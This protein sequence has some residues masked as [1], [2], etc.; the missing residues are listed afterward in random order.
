MSIRKLLAGL[1]CLGLAG[2]ASPSPGPLLPAKPSVRVMQAPG[3]PPDKP[4]QAAAPEDK[5]LQIL[6]DEGLK[7]LTTALKTLPTRRRTVAKGEKLYPIE[8]NLQ[9]ADLVEAVRALADTLGLN[10]SIDPKVKGTVNVRASGRLTRGELLSILE[11]MLLVNG[12]ALVQIGKTYN[13]VPLEKAAGEGMPVYARDLPAAGMTAQVVLLDAAPAKEMAA[14][15]KPL[16]SAGGKIAEAPNNSLVI[17][18]YPANLE[19]LVHLVN[20]VDKQGLAKTSVSVV[21]VKNTDPTQI[22]P[23]LE[24]IFGAYGALSP[25]K[26]KGRGGVQFLAMPRMNAVMILAPSPQLMQRAEYWVRQLDLKTDTLA[27]IHVYNVENYRAR[28]LAD[29]LIQVYG[30]QVERPGVREIRPEPTPSWAV[31][32][33][34][35]LGAGEGE[36]EGVPRTGGGLTSGLGATGTTGLGATGRAPGL[37]TGLGPGL[38]PAAPSPRERALPLRGAA[39]AQELKEGVRIIPDEEN[40]L[41][42]IVA[43][44]YEWKIIQSLLKRLDVQPRQVMCEVLIAEITLTDDLR[45]GVEWFIN[46]RVASE[47]P[48]IIQPSPLAGNPPIEILKG[49]SAALQGIGGFTFAA[50]DALNQFRLVINML[51]TK[52]LVQVLASP[53]I[54]AANNQEAR[55]QI[56][57]EVPILTS[58]SIPLVSQTQSLQTQTVSYRSTGIILLVRPQI[59][60]KGM[61]TLDISQEVSAIDASAPATGVNSPTFLIRQARTSLITADNQTIILGGLIREDV[62]RGG[63]GVPGLRNLPLLG[64]LFGS[65][66]KGTGRTELILLITPHI[67]HSMEEGARIT[68]EVQDRIELKQLRGGTAPAPAPAPPAP[69]PAPAAPA[70]PPRMETY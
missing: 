60:A 44:P 56:G 9:N 37:G 48:T 31:P 54:I 67:I 21:R 58:Q 24:T 35:P 55:I 33:R 5:E 27:N 45:Y 11:T 2:C 41:L 36:G 49:A 23:E 68:R 69:A 22:I 65:E 62:T 10:Y 40:N 16:L 28:N 17:V 34:P 47:T 38:A 52:G 50:R 30:G 39:A 46:N 53:H 1:L 59:N 13:I 63:R 43:P 14:V 70:A 20:L 25:V 19:K 66:T 4:P 61:I 3:M 8:L 6:T 32:P 7:N 51:A 42:V 12:A 18:D 64:P 57:Q 26:D 29:L 15:L